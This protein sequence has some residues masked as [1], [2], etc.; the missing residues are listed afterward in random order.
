MKSIE[1]KEDKLGVLVQEVKSLRT[2]NSEQ[3]QR[4]QNWL[5]NFQYISEVLTNF[6]ID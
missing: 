4:M 1:E 3:S 5:K 6:S 2:K